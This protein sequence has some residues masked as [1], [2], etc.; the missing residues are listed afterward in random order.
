MKIIN[1]FLGKSRGGIEVVALDY[2]DALA[3]CGY[4]S[5]ILTLKK[6]NYTDYLIKGGHKMHYLIGRGLNP[7]AILHFIKVIKSAKPNVVFLHGTK[8][9]EF[10][11]N[12]FVQMC[13]PKVKF[14]GISHGVIN[15]KYKKLKYALGISNSLKQELNDIGITNTYLCQNTTKTTNISVSDYRTQHNDTIVIGSMGR[16]SKSKGFDVILHAISFLKNQGI[17]IKCKIAG[18]HKT[19]YENLINELSI[20]DEIECLGWINDKD[21]F[22]HSIDIY[23]SGARF[24]QFGLTLIEAM[25]RQCPVIAT[26]CSGPK[27]IITKNCGILVP[28]N[29]ATAL[30]NAIL[31]LV[32]DD[33]LRQ[34]YALN[35]RNR[36]LSHFNYSD[37]PNRLSKIIEDVCAK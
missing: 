14:I 16:A 23:V 10:G 8:A 12:R 11:T 24:E 29:D 32:Q 1:C 26:E 7:I 31:K 20:Q 9:I 35:G 15:K 3:E 5:E 27:E 33:N 18:P 36:I 4:E 2:A 19:D 34:T 25:A 13:C 37:L 6:R 28:I 30:A 17:N 21:A 22:Y